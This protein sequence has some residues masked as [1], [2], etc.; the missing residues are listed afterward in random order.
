MRISQKLYSSFGL[1]IFLIII[2]TV[3]GINK[4]STIDSTLHNE[5]EL[6]SNKLR[7]AINF[8]GSV[9]DR[10]ISV[11][12]VVLSENKDSSLFKTSIED[13]KKL[14]EFYSSS[15]KSMDEIFKNKDNFSEKELDIL[16]KIKSVES[17]TLPLV[18]E[19]VKL[20][21]SGDDSKALNLLISETSPSFK[22]WL[23]VINE[24]IDFQEQK[25]LSYL[26]EVRNV[27]SGFSTTM[28]V[29]LVLAIILA[30]AIAYF[31]SRQLI[32][33]V[34]RIQTGL[35]S[36]F[37]FLNRETTTITLVD[38]NSKDEFGTMAD[39]INKNIEKTK[40]TVVEDNQFIVAVSNFI[41]ELKAGNNLV[42]FDL[43]VNTPIFKELKK[44]LEE[45]QY[46]LEHTIARDINTL[47]DVLEKFKNKDYTVR[48][49]NPYATVAVTINELG[50][51]ICEILAEN[52]SNGLT[53]DKSSNVLLENVDK[54]NLSSNEAATSL[55]ETAAA[56]EEMT[57]NIRHH[58]ESIAKMS[59]LSSSVTSS[60]S[61]GEKLA[62]ETTIAMDEINVQ[63][64][65]VNE[66]IS[67]IDNIAFQTNI[68]SLNAAVEAATA[69]E[70]EKGFAVVAQEVRN[71][72]SR[73][74]EAAKQIK[75]IVQLATNK[76]N[77]GKEIANSMIEG[78][79]ELNVNISQTMHLIS[80]IQNASKEQLLGIEQINDAVNQLDQ[81]TQKNAS[82]ASQTQSIATLTDSIAKLI[83]KNADEKE[84][85]GKN[86]VKAKYINGLSQ[87]SFNIETNNSIKIEKAKQVV[88][89][90]SKAVTSNTSDDEWESF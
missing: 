17:K 63:V 26:S 57:S 53:L 59:K 39:T 44:S 47:L 75:D 50:D 86:D 48:F 31:I 70:A 34:N 78:Y 55:E 52:K 66:A 24:F 37:N 81:Q 73:S 6:T 28:I 35:Q 88:L 14:G 80:D 32:S 8:R 22:N 38:I 90:K 5:V 69:G 7:F 33:M 49:P 12:D 25:N 58:T 42:K 60:A 62:N 13:I 43:E 56:L 74:A 67:V 40:N 41:Q 84:F 23:K 1:M 72:A 82:I 18:E 61:Q 71:L 87:K 15:S 46:Y 64:N 76:A 89:T 45:L 9:H 83:V 30:S 68:L 27:A 51:V 85:I 21:L 77:Q 19:I 54:L 4:V 79:K 65:L 36:F 10:A 29:F 20:K 3:I 2:L 11:R 16:N